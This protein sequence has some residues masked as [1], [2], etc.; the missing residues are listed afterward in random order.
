MTTATHPV[1]GPLHRAWKS[2]S[3]RLALCFSAVV[4]SIL[5]GTLSVYYVEIVGTVSQRLDDYALR[6][7]KRLLS[8]YAQHGEAGLVEEIQ[9]LVS[10]GI[11]SQDEIFIYQHLDGAVWAGNAT[12][13]LVHAPRVA[14][15]QDLPVE[16][17]ARRFNGRV[18]IDDLGQQ[19]FLIVGSDLQALT[20]IQH[21]YMK[22]TALA[23]GLAVGLSLLGA[24]VFRRLM[25]KRAAEVRQAIRQAGQGNLHFR[26]PMNRKS[27]EFS[28]LEQDI[29]QMLEQLEQLVRG[30]RHVSHMVAH[31]LRTPLNRALHRV[32]A[33]KLAPESLRPALLDQVQ[34][35]LDHLQRLF[36]K[37]LLLAEVEAGVGQHNFE[38]L[39]LQQV[40]QEVLEYYE[41]LFSDRQ[42]ELQLALEPGGWVLG[43]SHLLANAMSNLLDNFL[44]YGLSA[45]QR[46][47]EV[48]LQR[49]GHEVQ[50]RLRDHGAG[51]APA[52]L[53]RL[54]EHFV[55]DPQHQ[56]QPGHGLGLASVKAIVRLHQGRIGWRLAQPGLETWVRLP[57]HQP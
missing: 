43:D 35:E 55:R 44:K 14:A 4:V 5:V 42:V 32:Q 17:E 29:N 2:S 13:D 48:H 27:D 23:L 30:I 20:D 26:I 15:L 53:E 16:Q 49:Q 12:I 8:V 11:D 21:R 36:S 45:E 18:K 40:L 31:N 19:R 24:M 57:L 39:D 9:R 10:D 22:A 7:S 54:S 52:M 3:F 47:L 25:D 33:A 51:V 50:L 1:L 41:P 6:N 38:P 28:L 46:C 56:Q 37:M 34:E